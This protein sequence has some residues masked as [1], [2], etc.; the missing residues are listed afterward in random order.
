MREKPQL[1]PRPAA[2]IVKKYPQRPRLAWRGGGR[3]A[4][5]SAC[6]CSP[7]STFDLFLL[8]FLL[9]ASFQSA[10]RGVAERASCS[11]RKRRD[12]D[13]HTQRTLTSSMTNCNRP[14]QFC[15]SVSTLRK[16]WWP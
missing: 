14:S 7:G 2:R 1:F 4:A 15:N 6:V 16:L 10:V 13:A 11:I 8:I 9:A 5:S 3:D 12:D